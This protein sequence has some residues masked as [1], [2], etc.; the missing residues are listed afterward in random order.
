M[1]VLHEGGLPVIFGLTLALV[2]LAIIVDS[3]RHRRLH[4]AFGWGGSLIVLSVPARI[5]LAGTPAW[6]SF[7][8]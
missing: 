3:V 5:M 6:N 7:A 4:P 8:Q 2:L 1:G